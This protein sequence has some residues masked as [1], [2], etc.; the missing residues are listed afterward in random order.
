MLLEGNPLR[1]ESLLMLAAGESTVANRG[2][3]LLGQ[4]YCCFRGSI[5]VG[6][7]LCSQGRVYCCW[8]ESRVAGGDLLLQGEYV[9]IKNSI[10]IT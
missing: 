4:I 2:L 5:V 6:G 7:V 10:Q 9:I 1:G 3:M 8:K